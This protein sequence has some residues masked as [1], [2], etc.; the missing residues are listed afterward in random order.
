MD[1]RH[2]IF[3][4]K[5]K[6]SVSGVKITKLALRVCYVFGLALYFLF[7]FLSCG[8]HFRSSSLFFFFLL[9]L[10]LHLLLS[11]LN[12]A[13]QMHKPAGYLKKPLPETLCIC[14]Y[15]TCIPVMIQ[16]FLGGFYFKKNFGLSLVTL[17]TIVS[18]L[19][20]IEGMLSSQFS[21]F[22]SRKCVEDGRGYSS[23]FK[24][25]FS[26]ITFQV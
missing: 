11:Q 9:L 26:S 24:Y 20:F 23:I 7:F 8:S 16:R 1:G 18:S 3:E 2:L 17:F 10:L 21:I 5:K 6:G 19:K 14:V 12:K 13:T 4:R 22:N 15:I 25:Y